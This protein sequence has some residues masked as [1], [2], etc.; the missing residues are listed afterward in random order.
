LRIGQ[1][2]TV[3]DFVA[4]F[5]IEIIQTIVGVLQGCLGGDLFGLG[6]RATA[7]RK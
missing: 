5:E 6:R 4:T 3:Q 1:A 2:L 7:Q